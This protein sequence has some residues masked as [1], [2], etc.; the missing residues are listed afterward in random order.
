MKK[1]KITGAKERDLDNWGDYARPTDTVERSIKEANDIKTLWGVL[2]WD[3][4][5]LLDGSRQAR[6][7][8]AIPQLASER[9][10]LWKSDTDSDGFLSL[11]SQSIIAL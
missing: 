6:M 2:C 4:I 9:C 1:A 11:D 5:P 8:M 3:A 7:G 10:P